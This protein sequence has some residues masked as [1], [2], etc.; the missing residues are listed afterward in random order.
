MIHLI[1]KWKLLKLL[2][3]IQPELMVMLGYPSLE[4][5]SVSDQSSVE[6]FVAPRHSITPIENKFVSQFSHPPSILHNDI[7]QSLEKSYVASTIVKKKN[8][9]FFMF[10]CLS[11]SRFCACL[12]LTCSVF[13]H[14]GTTTECISC[15]FHSYFYVCSFKL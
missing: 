9:S 3:Q 12:S 15:A 13:K 6:P 5:N 4:V 7:T 10:A 1:M 11:N 8:Y 2:R 14:H